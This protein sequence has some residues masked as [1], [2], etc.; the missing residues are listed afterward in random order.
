MT[1]EPQPPESLA[2]ERLP[3][4]P[5]LATERL[6]LRPMRPADAPALQ[7]LF[8]DWEVVKHLN[9]HVPWPYPD[10]GAE[11]HI[12][13]SLEKRDRY[14]W[15]LTFRG[16][17]D[18]PLG[19]IS[20]HPDKG[21]EGEQRGFWLGRPY[22]GRGL[23]TEAAE[24]VTQHA[25]V[26]L[27]WPHLWLGNAEANTA[28]HRVK[29]KQGARIITRVPIRTVSGD[30]TKVVWLLTRSDWLA[31]HPEIAPDSCA[32]APK[33]ELFPE[34]LRMPETPVLETERL[35]LR[36]IRES[37]APAIQ[38]GFDNWE[39]VKHLSA[40]VPWPYPADGA[41]TNMTDVMREYAEHEKCFWAITLKGGDDELIGRID[42]WTDDGLSRTQ[43][44]FWLARGHWGRGLMTEAA[45]RVTEYAF[46]DLGWP[47]LWLSNAE[48]NVASHRVKEKQGAMLIDRT[49]ARY[50][51]GE[52]V[53][54]TW[55][56]RRE[57]WLARHGLSTHAKGPG[58][59]A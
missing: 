4:P 58:G 7:R 20:I 45:E 44:G 49:P 11:T 29:E 8:N 1:S 3:L 52:G 10:D 56:L 18:E 28:S 22:W 25:F 9:A 5:V 48:D 31:R 17:E 53:R 30:A 15:T 55:L 37:D 24:R 23:M 35:I 26:D 40:Q 12:R 46:V 42:L 33:P 59:D 36:R 6:I 34:R 38:R 27:G 41:V 2:D 51:S 43:R 54:V 47:H 50:V 13:T 57:P 32:S 21:D 39:V 19:L 16:A 14:Y